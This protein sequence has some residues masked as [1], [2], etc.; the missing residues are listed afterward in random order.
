M[1]FDIFSRNVTD[2][3]S[4]QKTLY[5]A[6]SNNLC[7]CCISAL[8]QFN[9][10]LI[11]LLNLFDSRLTFIL[12]YNFLNLVINAF[13]SGLLGGMAQDKRSR[14]RCSSWTVLPAQYTSALSSGFPISQCYAEALNENMMIWRWLDRWGETTKHRLISYFL[15][16]IC[17]KNYRNRIAYVSIIASQRWDCYWDTV[18]LV[19][20]RRCCYCCC[21]VAAGDV[22]GW[23]DWLGWLVRWTYGGLDTALGRDGGSSVLRASPADRRRSPV[24]SDQRPRSVRVDDTT[25][26]RRLNDVF[27]HSGISHNFNFN[28]NFNDLRFTCAQKLTYS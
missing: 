15:G 17:A 1:D 19:V 4:N 2:K 7:K 5:Y 12:L 14:E 22:Q 11:D 6:T 10:L 23:S 3:A 20:W 25:D 18:Q 28:F 8:P 9:Q 16:N 27:Q 21:S 26:V 24:S 13:I